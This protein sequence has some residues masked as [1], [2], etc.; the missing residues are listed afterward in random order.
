ME[1]KFSH[2]DVLVKNL[3]EACAYYALLPAASLRLDVCR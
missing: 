1:L 3:E 2:A